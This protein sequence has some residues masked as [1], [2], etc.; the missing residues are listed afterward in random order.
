MDKHVAIVG[1]GLAGLS[2]GCY[3]RA[4]GFRTTIIEHNASL[5]GVCT[6]WPRGEYTIDGCIHWLTGGPFSRLYEELGIVPAVALKPIDRW[7]TWRNG[8]AGG[9][10]DVTRDL[11][12]LSRDLLA[13]TIDDAPELAKVMEGARRFGEMVPPGIDQAPELATWAEQFRK[14]RELR[15]S[16]GL[17]VHFRKPVEEWAEDH[18]R[19]VMLRRFFTSLVPEG[20]PALLVLMVLGYLERSYLSRPVGGTGRFRDA[21]IATYARLGGE[22]VLGATVDEILVKDG[23]ARGVGLADGAQIDADAV[24]ST[25]NTPET[26]FRLLGGRFGA[27]ETIDRMNRWRMFQ[28]IVLASFGVA[29]PLTGLPGMVLVDGI[30]PFEIGGAHSDRLYL[31]ICND[32]PALAPLDHAVVQAMLPTDYEWWARCAGGYPRA[33]EEAARVAL[34]QIEHVVPGIA[35]R[36]RVTDVATPLTYW[37]K[38]RSWRGAYEGWMPNASSLFGHVRKTL[39]GLECFYMA[40][41]WVEP[42]GGVPMALMS[43]R[44][45]VQ[46]L[47]VDHARTFE[48]EPFRAVETIA[49]DQARASRSG[50]R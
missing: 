5:G 13:L 17:L 30:P 19:S 48:S 33:K 35:E 9:A 31:R 23:R 49:R 6:A 40:G 22:S 27:S 14:F 16:M 10:I 36:V 3:A 1:G 32:D 11:D 24:I 20:A 29:A 18:I 28:P 7:L 39:P 4:S 26:V 8:F 25:S 46:L 45:A 34:A 37:H 43:G 42:G 21:L 15:A 2:A 44:Q 50:V 38:T 41:Q 12:S 47:C